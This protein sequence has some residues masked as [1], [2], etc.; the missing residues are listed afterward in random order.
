MSVLSCCLE[1]RNSVTLT[2]SSRSS[3]LRS[4]NFLTD[5]FECLSRYIISRLGLFQ[6][7]GR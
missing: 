3:T 7:I 2:E 4:L 6:H 1:F 5:V